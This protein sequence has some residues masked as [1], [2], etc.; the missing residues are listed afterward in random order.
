MTDTSIY[1]DIAARTGGDIYLGLVGPVRTGKSTFIKRFMEALVIPN[2]E[3]VYAR[4]RAKDELPQSGSGRTVMTAEPKFVPEDAVSVTLDGGVSFSVRLIDCVGYMVDG[5]SGQFE[6]GVERMVATPWFDEEVPMS[7]AAEE[8]TRRVITDHS[9][10]GIVMT[11]DGT[12]CGIER[13]SYVPAEERVIEE[14]R[15]IGKPFVLVLN[16]ANPEGEAAQQLRAEL[17]EKYGV[18]CVCVSC[19]DLTA[20]DIDDIL[21]LALYEFPISELGI[22]LPSW[23]D[24]LDGDSPLRSGILGAIA[25]AFCDSLRAKD[26]LDYKL[27]VSSLLRTEEDVSRLRRSGNPN[28]SD[29]SAHCYGTTFDIT[30]T[31]YWRDEETNEFMQPFE[32]TKVLGE[33]LQER[34]AAGKCLVKY[35]KREHCFH[36]TSCY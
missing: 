4:E 23:L 12:V 32:L 30:Y 29:N 13:E 26:L 7:R 34:K 27:V 25:E 11:T 33:V 19:L 28:A 16:S 6:D 21:K 24:A 2:I 35:E 18:A 15:A 36:I 20:Q 1:Q 17:E 9:T 8:G 22:Y 3:D 10:I 14:L 5:A 31:R